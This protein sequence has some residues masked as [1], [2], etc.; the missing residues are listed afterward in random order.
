[1]N[2]IEAYL[3]FEPGVI[4]DEG[5]VTTDRTEKFLD[6]TAGPCRRARAY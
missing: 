5:E 3:Q 2:S 6:P 1:M 4:T